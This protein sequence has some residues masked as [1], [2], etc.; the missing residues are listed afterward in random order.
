MEDGQGL[1]VIA[2]LVITFINWLSQTLKQKAAKK[3]GELV[4]KSNE[5]A[6]A[7]KKEPQYIHNQEIAREPS[8]QRPGPEM[9]VREFLAA[10]SGSEAP[11]QPQPIPVITH[12]K[13][14][15]EQSKVQEIQHDTAISDWKTQLR[16]KTTG[17]KDPKP[18]PTFT[19]SSDRKFKKTHPIA[20]KL[21]REGGAKEAI[22]LSE[23][24][25]KPKAFTD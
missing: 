2:I 7:A 13:E 21:R 17:L 10:L 20:L 5:R 24:L 15:Q 1:I 3:D 11:Q 18:V 6:T 19:I 16:T 9:G 23:I 14:L 22:I 12:E 8:P 25:G 4:D